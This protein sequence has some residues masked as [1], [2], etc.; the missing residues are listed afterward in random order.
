MSDKKNES[1]WHPLDAITSTGKFIFDV[2]FVIYDSARSNRL[3]WAELLTIGLIFNIFVFLKADL[4]AFSV[5]KITGL[6]PSGLFYYAYWF[7]GTFGPFFMWSIWQKG[8]RRMIQSYL[9]RGF[10]NAGLVNGLGEYPKF[11]SDEEI[12]SVTRKMRLFHNGVTYSDFQNTDKIDK[13]ALALGIS[14]DEVKKDLKSPLEYSIIYGEGKRGYGPYIL[15][16]FNNYANYS[17]P[18]GKV[19]G[20]V[21]VATFDD[22]PHILV[23]GS[24]NGGKSTFIRSLVTILQQNNYHAD[25]RLFDLKGLLDAQ[26]FEGAERIKIFGETDESIKE[27]VSIDEIMNDRM[28]TY[29]EAR[30]TNIN[31]YNK[32]L[33]KCAK[34][35]GYTGITAQ[36]RVIVIIDECG[37]ILQKNSELNFEGVE[38]AKRV[39]NR[40]ARMGRAVGIHLVLGVQYPT[41]QT[42]EPMV[43]ANLPGVLCFYM[44]TSVGSNAALGNI[45][46]N[47]LCSET[48]GAAIW[49]FKNKQ[50]E[51][52][53]PFI[54]ADAIEAIM[55]PKN[56]MFQKG[57]KKYEKKILSESGRPKSP[58]H[59]LEVENHDDIGL[60][61]E[62]LQ[63]EQP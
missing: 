62:L 12:D 13:F 51:V 55:K 47:S 19:R 33:K 27:L 20:R 7:T 8:R 11:I 36:G 31:Q 26:V 21:E 44:G 4:L 32:Y 9:Q 6:Y 35:P 50:L 46:A 40:L 1:K 16:D 41:K 45:S 53:A 37:E 63:G 39:V 22:T 18:V 3:P 30:V 49:K 56:P 38:T 48:Q 29:R 2:L 58:T 57:S 52:Q 10:K 42:L 61:K 24:T 15:K 17:F 34:N 23:A 59:T 60:D 25:I 43:K 28:R 5:I 54:E 14:I